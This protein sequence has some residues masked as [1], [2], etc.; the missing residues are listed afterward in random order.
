MTAKL[1]AA[2][3]AAPRWPRSRVRRRE[4]R[5][6]AATTHHRGYGCTTRR[7]PKNLHNNSS[8][9]SMRRGHNTYGRM[10]F[11]SDSGTFFSRA[12]EQPATWHARNRKYLL[13]I[14]L[15]AGTFVVQTGC[16]TMGWKK[17]RLLIVLVLF[18][19]LPRKRL[20]N[21]DAFHRRSRFYLRTLPR[22]C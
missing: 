15:D 2:A 6:P 4:W 14:C 1:L 8:R 7:W 13:S 18:L 10:V 21:V 11:A 16:G 3:E 12:A 5:L 19:E 17:T 9:W 20:P 22:P